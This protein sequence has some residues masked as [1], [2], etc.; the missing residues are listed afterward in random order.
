MFA[1]PT[2][3]FQASLTEIN[4]RLR[5]EIDIKDRVIQ[6]MRVKLDTRIPLPPSPS[7]KSYSPKSIRRP[8]AFP[9][10]LPT[11]P[12]DPSKPSY[13]YSVTASD[14]LDVLVGETFNG[15]SCKF[16]LIRINRGFYRIRATELE[17]SQVNGKI[18]A[19]ADAWNNGKFGAFRKF[20]THF[21]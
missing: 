2:P 20:L 3:V 17:V 12:R 6:D 21:E 16:P 8:I 5:A 13:P 11:A 18:L 14:P 1:F 4:R 19:R 7:E 15:T 10:R 9:P